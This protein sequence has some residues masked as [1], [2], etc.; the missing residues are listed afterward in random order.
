MAINAQ[1]NTLQA[2]GDYEGIYPQTIPSYVE[3]LL[4]NNLNFRGEFK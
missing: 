1:I 2:S 3:N 4:N